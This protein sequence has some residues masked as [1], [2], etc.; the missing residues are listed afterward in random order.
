MTPFE[1]VGA[2]APVCVDG[3]C[4]IPAPPS[5]GGSASSAGAPV[6]AEAPTGGHDVS[7]GPEAAPAR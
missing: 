3:V 7:G 1:M 6:D 2:E 4:E 5:S